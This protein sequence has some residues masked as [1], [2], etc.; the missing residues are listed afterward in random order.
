MSPDSGIAPKLGSIF[1][2]LKKLTDPLNL[3]DRIPIPSELQNNSE[4][5]NF[6]DTI[7]SSVK[8]GIGLN[9]SPLQILGAGGSLL[10]S[11][12]NDGK[13]TYHCDLL[14]TLEF[15]PGKE[16][17]VESIKKSQHVQNYIQ[18]PFPG[19]KK[20]YMITGLKIATGFT[21][22]EV[23]NSN[24]G[25]KLEVTVDS[26]QFGVPLEGG[27]QVELEFGRSRDLS[28]GGSSKIIFAYRAIKIRPRSD[29]TAKYDEISGGLYGLGDED[30]GPDWEIEAMDE[31]A[32]ATEFPGSVLIPVVSKGEV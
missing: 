13:R 27:P 30:D 20:V 12:A 22:T 25:P 10:Y 9:A 23:K 2:N 18:R 3:N 7:G 21:M 24:H 26:T 31:D 15:Q 14:E 29:G 4:K 8:G 6:N 19:P 11:F 5:T 1:P 28:Q 16:Y 32:I 17:V